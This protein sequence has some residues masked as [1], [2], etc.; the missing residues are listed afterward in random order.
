MKYHK[1]TSLW[2]KCLLPTSFAP[3]RQVQ[4]LRPSFGAP[5]VLELIFLLP[6]ASI[7]ALKKNTVLNMKGTNSR[8]GPVQGLG[9]FFGF[10]EASFSVQSYIAAGGKPCKK[11]G[12]VSVDVAEPSPKRRK[13]D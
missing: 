8:F 2:R 11:W 3:Y 10:F 4:V 1:E 12:V 9:F 13:R 5:H 6:H 7:T